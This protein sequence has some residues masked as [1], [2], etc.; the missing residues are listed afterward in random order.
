M[1][2][3]TCTLNIKG[4]RMRGQITLFDWDYEDCPKD[5]DLSQYMNPPE[6]EEG[7][8]FAD[9]ERPNGES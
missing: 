4:V 2:T 9:T 6:G 3:E 7:G 8:D 5:F 1:S